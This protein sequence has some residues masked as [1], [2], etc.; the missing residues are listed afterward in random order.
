MDLGRKGRKKEQIQE[1]RFHSQAL[2]F[3]SVAQP[4]SKPVG[5][6]RLAASRSKGRLTL[7]APFCSLRTEQEST[8]MPRS[9]FD[10]RIGAPP[11]ATCTPTCNAELFARRAV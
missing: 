1:I 7:G 11:G 9:L 10:A 6:R 5:V 4:A 8:V 2:D 3:L